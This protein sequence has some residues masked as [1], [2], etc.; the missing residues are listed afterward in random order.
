MVSAGVSTTA[1]LG[2]LPSIDIFWFAIGNVFNLNCDDLGVEN[3]GQG[4]NERY[5]EASM[6]QS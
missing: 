2:A 6:F 5:S 4:E 3:G 1:P